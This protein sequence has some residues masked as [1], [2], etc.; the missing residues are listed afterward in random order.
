MSGK[1]STLSDLLYQR[2][3]ATPNTIAYRFFK[4][5][6]L[7]VDEL[8]YDQLWRVAAQFALHLRAQGLANQRV[9]LVC[10]S[11]KHFVIAFY[12]CML[13]GAI[14][15]PTALPRRRALAGRL[16]LLMQDA[17][18]AAIISDVEEVAE[19]ATQ[20]PG[21]QYIALEQCLAE[22]SALVAGSTVYPPFAQE[23][24][25]AFL[26]Y[27]SG[28]TGDPKGVVITHANLMC[29]SRVIQQAMS[30][31]EHSS[32][33]TA[34]PLFH[35]MG[36]VGGMLQ[37]MFAGCVAN[38]MSPAEF[39]QYPERWLQIMSAYKITVSGGPNFMYQLAATSITPEQIPDCD[40]SHW[41]VA[42]CG[43]E[44]IRAA[45][46]RLF[47]ERFASVG[48]RAEAFYPCYGMAESTLFITGKEISELPVVSQFQG[49]QV[50]SCGIPRPD[51]EV[52]IVDPATLC[53]LPEQHVG[54]IWARGGS[55]AHGYWRRPELSQATFA[56]HINEQVSGQVSGHSRPGYL[57]TGD[58]G[59]MAN[60]QLYVTGRLKD[61]II[62]YGKKY[63]PQD[64]ENEAQASHPALLDCP[65]VAFAIMQD[66]VDRLIVV[67]E[68]KRD[69]ARQQEQWPEL[70]AA[71]RAAVN[72]MHG[73]AL[74][75]IVFI[76]QGSLPRTSSGKVR[77][78]QCRDDYLA[79]KLDRVLP[80]AG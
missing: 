27:T 77:R 16:Q 20:R 24:E 53:A 1:L 11:Q 14:A 10:K 2:A 72:N 42:F 6:K 37:P 44:P 74:D 52:E 39:V 55:V 22:Q 67:F 31:Y 34:L 79:G 58:L 15:V 41:S 32:M 28:S 9:L 57:R 13:A 59:F 23:Q 38:C 40:L 19:F 64:I 69:W 66:A 26:Q 68:L 70:M 51:T 71:M 25:I 18:V 76:R 21:M 7:S 65:G 45:T 17:D 48:L 62:V 4:G 49:A 33:F 54:E 80:V 30:I 63:A 73:V 60:G 3:C 8:S 78:S 61:L 36:L 35:D 29:N 75:D 5:P 50:V 56:A 47:C 43:A 46:M 12:G